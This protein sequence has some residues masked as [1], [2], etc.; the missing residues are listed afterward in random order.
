[1]SSKTWKIGALAVAGL[2]VVGAAV[3]WASPVDAQGPQ[4][5]GQ[6]GQT[7][8]EAVEPSA[9]RRGQAAVGQNQSA[10]AR[11]GSGSFDLSESEAEAL[12]MALDDEY[13]AW[14][15]YDQVIADFGEV[16][17]FVEI[18]AS[19]EKHIASLTRLFDRYGLDMPANEWPGNVPTFASVE[20]ACA[21]GVAAEEENA[22]LYEQL[23]S[24]VDN[25]DIVRV[26]TSLQRASTNNHL[27]A[28]QSC[29]S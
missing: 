11:G 20:E 15:I 7:G 9:Q 6:R 29:G 14:A 23:F 21:A 18:K 19:E 25:P 10:G 17:P 26:F 28:F 12:Q 24:M 13:K 4:G 3:A 2:V 22:E 27:A 1:M 5:Y 16:S 8:T